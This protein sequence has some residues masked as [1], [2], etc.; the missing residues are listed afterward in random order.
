M[1]KIKKCCAHCHEAFFTKRNP[2]QQYCN[3]QAC[4]NARKCHW[5][6]QKRADDPDYRQNQRRANQKWQKRCSLYWRQY[7]ATHADYTQR[8]RQQ[9]ANRDRQRSQKS[10]FGDASFLAKSDALGG[11]N[12]D[13]S[14]C[15]HLVRVTPDLAKSDALLVKI[16]LITAS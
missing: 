11:K 7:R 5:R 3:H 14:G 13:L 6:K 4:Q 9:Q 2:L 1:E 15:Y 12:P 16:S 10:H 8:N